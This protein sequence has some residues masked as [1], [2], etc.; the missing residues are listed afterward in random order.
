MGGH[1]LLNLETG[2]GP[3]P[4]KKKK[5]KKKKKRRRRKSRCMRL[6]FLRDFLAF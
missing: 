1:I 5:N 3:I 4:L 2:Q 6:I